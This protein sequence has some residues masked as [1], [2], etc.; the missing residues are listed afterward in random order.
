[1]SRCWTMP[2]AIVLMSFSMKR[3]GGDAAGVER[4]HGELRAR[5]ADALGGDDADGQALFDDAVGAHVHAVA[6]GADAA[7]ALA[8]ERGADAD[9]LE[10]QLLDLVGDLVGDDLVFRDDR[11][12]GDRVAD[13]VAG[14][15][16]D[17][18]V[19]QLDLDGLAL[20]DRALGDAVERAALDLVDDDVLRHVGQLAGEVPGV[21][22]LEG[23]VGQS[24]A[25]AVGGGEVFE[26]REAFAEVGLDRGLD[27]LAGGL[28][29]QAAHAAELAD[30]VDVTAGAGD[31][32]HGDGV[33]VAEL[34]AGL[35]RRSGRP[36]SSR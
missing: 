10:L 13:R 18:H 22:G 21:G 4:T 5:L 17:D 1:M 23:G 28:G 24:L 11:L 25:G 33:E 26:H 9:A 31:G 2:P 19:L 6:T 34:P 20:I 27:D 14:G 30:L 29:H 12:V 16:A 35:R 15:S 36:S 8:G 3:A 32:H 7:R